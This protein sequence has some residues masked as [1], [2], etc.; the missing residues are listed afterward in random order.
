MRIRFFALVVFEE[1]EEEDDAKEGEEFVLG[2]FLLLLDTLFLVDFLDTLFIVDFL[3]FFFGGGDC[4]S[5]TA[6]GR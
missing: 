1:D 2:L 3:F 5:F 6:A 4:S